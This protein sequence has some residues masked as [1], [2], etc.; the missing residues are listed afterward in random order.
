MSLSLLNGTTVCNEVNILKFVFT[1]F[2]FMRH[3][4]INLLKVVFSTGVVAV[5]RFSPCL[6]SFI[7]CMHCPAIS[8]LPE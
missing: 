4:K 3:G 2:L 5:I 6:L 8:F 7:F 1:C